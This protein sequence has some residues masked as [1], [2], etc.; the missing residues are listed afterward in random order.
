MAQRSEISIESSYIPTNTDVSRRRIE[1]V[2]AKRDILA[3]ATEAGRKNEPRSDDPRLD[4]TQLSLIDESQSFVASVTRLAGAETTDRINA[5]HGLMPVPL[6]TSLEQSNIRRAVAETKDQFKDDLDLAHVDR[7]RGLRELRAFEE[8]SGL[9]PLSAIYGQDTA[10]FVASLALLILFESVLN[11]FLLQELQENGLIGGLIL[12]ATVGLANVL[13]GLGTGYL[14]WRLMIHVTW[15][16][17]LLGCLLTVLFMAGALALHLALGDLREAITHDVKAQIDF[18]VI[19]K[20]ARWLAYT[21]IQPFVLFAV[22]I[23][24]FVIAALKGRGGTWGVVSPYFGHDTLDRRFREADRAFEDA[25]ANLKNGVQDSFDG[26]RQKLRA[27]VASETANLA[28]IRGLATRAYGIARTLSDSIGD[29]IGRLHIWLRMYRDRNRAVRDTPPPASFDVYESFDE[30][31]A[32]RLDL[33][34]VTRLVQAAE[35]TLAENTAKLA[36]LE[37]QTLKEQVATIDAMLT[38]VSASERRAALQ[39]TKDDG[40][41]DFRTA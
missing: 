31:R 18:L 15:S 21:S 40:A 16:R 37:D 25:K 14:G 9:A 11:A 33:S 26:E 20:P 8:D 36:A 27:R 13:L 22:G 23:A 7:Q 28:T 35:R 41:A 1:E 10:M 19:L 39:V 29:E 34:E 2:A 5:M 6:D 3:R 30:W 24:T 38:V 32:T 17:R 12:A 4:E